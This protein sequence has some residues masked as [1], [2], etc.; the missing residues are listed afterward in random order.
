MNRLL[1]LTFLS[2]L[3]L[4]LVSTN[5]VFAQSTF[6]VDDDNCPGPGTGTAADPFCSVQY[7][8]NSVSDGDIII[9]NP[10]TYDE[11]ITIQ[12][13]ITLSGVDKAATFLTFTGSAVEQQV[14]LGTNTGLDLNGPV[15]I[16]NFTLL[17]GGSLTGDNDLIK[18]R[19]RGVGGQITIQD[20]I[21][22]CDGDGSLTP[23]KAI[24]EAYEASNFAITGN[25]FNNCRYGVWFNG[26]QNGEVS[27]NE[28]NA[29]TSGS[30]GMGG[31][32]SG[33][34]AP[35]NL[36]ISGNTM[37]SG[38]YGLVL[39]QNIHDI[40]FEC[41]SISNNSY[42]GILTWEFGPEDWS[43]VHI[44]YN[45]IEGNTSGIQGY[46]SPAGNPNIAVDALEN[47]WGAAD[48]PGGNGPGSG[49][50]VL[51][52]NISYNPWQTAEIGDV[53]PPV[54]DDEG[55]VTYDVAADPNPVAAGT[56]SQVA[57]TVDDSTTG[58][59]NI[60]SAVYT[61]YDSLGGIVTS[62]SML[63]GFDSPVENVWADFTAPASAGIYDLC[64]YGTD[65]PGNVGAESC[66]M[67]VVYD[68]DGGFVTGG[69]WIESPQGAFIG[70]E[71]TDYKWDQDFGTDVSG[72]FDDD[73]YP[74]YG[75]INWQ[76]DSTALV[77]GKLDADGKYYGPFS[78]FDGFRDV[79]PG[80]WYA[81]IDVYIDPEIFNLGEGFDYSVAATGADGSHQRDYIFHVT[82]DT[83]TGKLLV[84]GSNNT[85]FAPREDLDTLANNHEVTT[86]GWYTF[87]HK[88]YDTGGFLAVD[89]NLL[90]SNGITLFTE[91]RSDPSDT[92]PDEV[93]GNRYSWFTHVTVA[94]G[95]K[96]DNH[97]LYQF[98]AS[99]PVGKANFGFVAKYNKKTELPQGNTE[100][101]FQA[102]EINFHSSSYDWLVVNKNDS[103]AQ[104]KG[105]G[106]IN[107]EG[108]YKFMLWAVDGEPDTFRIKIWY[109]E[110]GSEIVVYDNGFD[111]S[112]FENGQPISGGN[113][114]VHTKN[115]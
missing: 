72:W 67:L 105:D 20:N 57:A 99:Y 49:D 25:E 37:D 2:L 38:T 115:K 101:V 75:F 87:Q 22:D 30:I 8:I 45:N 103:R 61:I 100:F 31:S 86:A 92:I 5:Q 113:I 55:P 11:T 63:D 9:V 65:E 16:E 60:A 110:D 106:T 28:F 42:T 77:E 90:D 43:N 112:G 12:K 73:D 41:N 46:S 91:T 53:C 83:S 40:T 89:L 76:S 95:I 21:F 70:S 48:G 104:F 82:K 3:I 56:V 26:A 66:A 58:G 50:S 68:P 74:G 114:V 108:L 69:G 15:T 29:S 71:F 32:A 102:G 52:T 62:A 7:A 88:F 13:P 10:G 85:N 34:L 44:N 94:G 96:V 107:N 51:L 19:A 47:W 98:S 6:Y 84:A 27:S 14:F 4:L 35:H 109:E 59:S 23:A 111:G 18:F 17:N 81:E 78:R 33:A 39:A 24:E 93:G 64:V 79:W 1:K 36:S 54:A 80:T 97:Q